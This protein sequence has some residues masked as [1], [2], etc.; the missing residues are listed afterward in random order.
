MHGAGGGRGELGKGDIFRNVAARCSDGTSGTPGRALLRQG[1]GVQARALMAEGP[2]KVKLKSSDFK[3]KPVKA[4]LG[5][6]VT[7]RI[8]GWRTRL[9]EATGKMKTVDIE[10][11][12]CYSFSSPF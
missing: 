5:G 10:K 2:G 6:D 8:E 12:P 1:V 11:V 4:W 3:F 7:E 9:Y